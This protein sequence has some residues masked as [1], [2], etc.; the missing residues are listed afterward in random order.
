MA[1]YIS[2]L[3][4]EGFKRGKIFLVFES[5]QKCKVPKIEKSASVQEQLDLIRENRAEIILKKTRTERKKRRLTKVKTT[6]MQM[7]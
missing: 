5:R 1:G 6:V 2:L 4:V 3:N 7:S